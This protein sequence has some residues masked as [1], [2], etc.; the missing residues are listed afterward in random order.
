MSFKSRATVQAGRFFAL[1]L[2]IVIL[3]GC[4]G[5]GSSSINSIK[6]PV[7]NT[8]AIQVN[9]GPA[10]NF[11]NGLFTDVTICVPGSTTNCQTITN[12][13]VDTGSEGLRL[14]SSQVTLTLPA[15][16]D[17]TSNALQECVSFAD[18][19]FVWGPVASADILMAG[20]KASSVSIQII[21]AS[22]TLAVPSQCA[23]GG[24][25]DLNTVTALGANG[26]L[27]VG[28]FRQDC[29]T[30]CTS[31]SAQVQPFYFLCPNTVCQVATVPLL[32][33]LQNPVWMFPQDNNG[34]LITLPSIPDT[35]ATSVSG[36]MIFGVGTQADNALG[37]AQ[38]YT[39]DNKGNFQTTFNGISFSMSFIDSG[40]NGL[41]ILD[42]TKLNIPDCTDRPGFYC[43]PSITSF[44]ATNTGLNGTTAPVIFKIANADT[45]F[46]SNN[47][48]NAAFDDLGGPNPDTFDWG[49]PFFYGRPV[50][51][52]IEGQ[53]APSGVLGPY[54]AY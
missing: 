41:F 26:I 50:F 18:G 23:S 36:S 24:G 52:G 5:G 11:V 34:L 38:I 6:Q 20:E 10:N 13:E 22:P 15:V 44:T 30:G 51:V 31:A 25:S 53:P 4:G 29:G 21:S 27:G 42:S 1:A 35:G 43:P 7:N 28:N 14:L 45:L 49:L 46:A 48:Q 16:T 32:T 12:V 39:T 17:G 2:G 47:G 9:A 3:A 37:S 8:Q 33:Q 54:W 40:S 19:S